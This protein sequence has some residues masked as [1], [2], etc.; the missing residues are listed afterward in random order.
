MDVPKL[1]GTFSDFPFPSLPV[2]EDCWTDPEEEAVGLTVEKL[3]AKFEDLSVEL[4]QR[5][6]VLFICRASG[7]RTEQSSV[8]YI[9]H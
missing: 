5:R 4:K 7:L 3:F 9:C 8:A 1:Q 6:E 2:G